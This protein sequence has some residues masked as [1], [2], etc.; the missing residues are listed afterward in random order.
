MHV[1]DEN[2]SNKNGEI[3]SPNRVEEKEERYSKLSEEKLN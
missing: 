1:N 3:S 2:M